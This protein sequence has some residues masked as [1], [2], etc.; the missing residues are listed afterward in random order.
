MEIRNN[1][2][3][4]GSVVIDTV[5]TL[6]VK[7]EIGTA[8]DFK[9]VASL[10][11]AGG[12]VRVHVKVGND[13]LDGAVFVNHVENYID[14]GSVTNFGGTPAIIAGTAELDSGKM[15]LTL[16]MTPVSAAKSSTRASSNK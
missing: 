4:V 9:K 12:V 14:I 8:E 7:T 5:V 2:Y 15:Y 11:D 6:G 1:G 16:S 10:A 3:N 13:Q